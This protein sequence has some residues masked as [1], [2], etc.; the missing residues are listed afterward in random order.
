MIPFI[1]P[2]YNL[3]VYN[4]SM[5]QFE[6]NSPLYDTEIRSMYKE[7]VRNHITNLQHLYSWLS[8]LTYDKL[9]NI[10]LMYREEKIYDKGCFLGH[11]FDYTIR[12][13]AS[14][15]FIINKSATTRHEYIEYRSFYFLPGYYERVYKNGTTEYIPENYQMTP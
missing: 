12:S 6:K 2:N 4:L 13:N 3:L 15:I 8:S 7:L 1:P 10:Q 11:V 9:R 5:T 14:S